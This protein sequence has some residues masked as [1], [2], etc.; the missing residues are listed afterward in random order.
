M[1]LGVYFAF[2]G[3]LMYV[4]GIIVLFAVILLNYHT[5]KELT[6]IILGILIGLK[7][8]MRRMKKNG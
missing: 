3:I 8:S 4:I 6:R 2:Q 5:T 7:N 1:L